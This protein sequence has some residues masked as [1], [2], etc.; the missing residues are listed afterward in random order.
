MA[1]LTGLR[2]YAEQA[3]D[4]TRFSGISGKGK[5]HPKNLADHLNGFDSEFAADAFIVCLCVHETLDALQVDFTR[6]RLDLAAVNA[7][8]RNHMHLNWLNLIPSLR[9]RAVFIGR[10]VLTISHQSYSRVIASETIIGNRTQHYCLAFR[11]VWW[12]VKL[13]GEQTTA[14]PQHFDARPVEPS[15]DASVVIR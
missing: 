2:R 3:S 15:A 14:D 11:H 1:G 13:C 7:I 10:D 4:Q 9:F 8:Q 6:N 5:L 12:V